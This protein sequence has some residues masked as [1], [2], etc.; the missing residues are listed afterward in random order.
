M[1]LSRHAHSVG[2]MSHLAMK[3][4]VIMTVATCA[5]SRALAAATIPIFIF[6]SATPIANKR[7]HSAC[8]HDSAGHRYARRGSSGGSC[9]AALG[10]TIQA[11]LLAEWRCKHTAEGYQPAQKAFSAPLLSFWSR[12]TVSAHLRKLSYR[13]RHVPH[14]SVCLVITSYVGCP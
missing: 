2:E 10:R 8:F 12:P 9:G 6:H 5:P 7:S 3:F 14:A 13:A 1:A 11:L 4:L